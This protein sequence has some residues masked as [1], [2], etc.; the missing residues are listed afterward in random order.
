MLAILVRSR[1]ARML[2]SALLLFVGASVIYLILS[3]SSSPSVEPSKPPRS[4]AEKTAEKHHRAQKK[5][6]RVEEEIAQAHHLAQPIAPDP[7]DIDTDAAAAISAKDLQQL[8]T[9][10]RE[11][12]FDKNE[13]LSLDELEKRLHENAI[14][15]LDQ[16]VIDVGAEFARVDADATKSVTWQEWFDYERAKKTPSSEEI[17]EDKDLFSMAD[18]DES[19]KLSS[20]EFL[21]FRHPELCAQTLE[22]FS[23]D[24]L[25]SLDN[26]GDGRVSMD[27]Y[28]AL[29][30]GEVPPDV[31]QREKQWQERQRT[32]FRHIDLNGDGS[33]DR[34]ELEA[35][36]NPRN[37][38]HA[39]NEAQELLDGA[40]A[41]RD[42]QLAWSE[43]ESDA[44]LFLGSK[45][46][47]AA[48]SLHHEF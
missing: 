22:E 17:E 9:A 6:D 4:A 15:H 7:N 31:E 42:A 19:G 36:L 23:R 3:S 41:N 33:L 38:L 13:R 44:H 1:R 10:F 28:V 14:E 46:V 16:A 29:P 47:D 35:F 30:P 5:I 25:E 11:A 43:V 40:D 32:E 21:C 8:K 48:Q 39:K 18:L 45:L 12:D 26:D 34:A 27:E 24:T 37:P 20:H 2:A